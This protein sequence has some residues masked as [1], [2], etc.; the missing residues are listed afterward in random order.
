[1]SLLQWSPDLSVNVKEIDTQHKKLVDLINLLH[2][3]MKS[4]KGKDVLSQVLND[5]TDYTVYHF[6]T[7]EKL[8]EK[9]G[10]PEYTRHKKEHDDLTKQVIEIKSKFEAGQNTITVE[11]MSFLK[12]WLNNHIKHSDKRYTAFLNSKGV[13]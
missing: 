7:E 8:F 1:M 11:V 10:Y 4:G 12:D 13:N 6:S 2:D 9:Y 3:S 5:L